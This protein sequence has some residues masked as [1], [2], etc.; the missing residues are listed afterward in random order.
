MQF[1]VEHLSDVSRV[2]GGDL[3]EMLVLAVIGQA[4]MRADEL[5][6]ENAPINACRI[7]ET[8]GIPRQTVRRKPRRFNEE[9]GFNR[10][11]AAR[12]N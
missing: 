8:T 10:S 4:Y 1:F 11:R 7:S 2:F 5:G 12:G 3:Q 9:A 6:R